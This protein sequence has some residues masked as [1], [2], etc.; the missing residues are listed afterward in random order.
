MAVSDT[1]KAGRGKHLDRRLGRFTVNST[2]F[3]GAQRGE[4]ENLFHRMIVLEV[5]HS[6]IEDR[7]YYIGWHPDFDI[8]QDGAVIP[9]YEAE[10][11]AQSPYP[12]WRMK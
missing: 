4:G 9:M 2:F 11:D 12:K 3:I 5:Q 8:V 1:P 6:P 7:V 10:F